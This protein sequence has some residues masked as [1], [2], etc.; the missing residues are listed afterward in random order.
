[1][2]GVQVDSAVELGGRS[3][4]FHWRSISWLIGVLWTPVTVNC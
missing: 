1:L 2:V 4:V 3:V